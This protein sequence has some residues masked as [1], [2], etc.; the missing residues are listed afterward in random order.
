VRGRLK[1]RVLDVE[2]ALDD[3]KRSYGGKRSRASSR[4]RLVGVW[5]DETR[6][7]P[8]YGTN[9]PTD[10]TTDRL[11]AEDIT[12]TYAALGLVELALIFPAK[13]GHAVKQL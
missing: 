2:V 9:I 1:G 4:C 5:N 7:Y 8:L 12:R 3:R 6:K 13:N 10:R 11:S